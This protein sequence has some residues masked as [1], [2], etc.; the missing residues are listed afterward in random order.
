MVGRPLK[1]GS[2]TF[3]ISQWSNGKNL[4]NPKSLRK[5]AIKPILFK[6][7]KKGKYDE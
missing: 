1:S 2:L 4:R 6:Q 7:V 5:R 3:R